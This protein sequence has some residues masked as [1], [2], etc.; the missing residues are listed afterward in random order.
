MAN[1]VL[2]AQKTAPQSNTYLTSCEWRVVDM[3]T[4]Y[5]EHCLAGKPFYSFPYFR[6]V[7]TL[8]AI[9]SESFKA[10]KQHSDTSDIIFSANMAMNVFVSVFTSVEFLSKGLLTL[11]AAGL[12]E[13]LGIEEN[14]TAFQRETGKV[15]K[16][17]VDLIRDD[18]FYTVPYL[19]QLKDLYQQFYQANDKSLIDAY[20]LFALSIE[21]FAKSLISLPFWG[22]YQLSELI[23]HDD[24]YWQRRLTIAYPE[25]T[26]DAEKIALKERLQNDVASHIK[27]N[28]NTCY[29]DQIEFEHEDGEYLQIKCGRYENL[30]TVI[31]I[32][33]TLKF[34]LCK[35]EGNDFVQLCLKQGGD[36]HQEDKKVKAL[37]EGGIRLNYSYQ[38]S[39]KGREQT[40]FSLDV[41]VRELQ[42]LNHKLDQ[43]DTPSSHFLHGF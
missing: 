26:T 4:E 13:L 31:S 42:A 34:S 21:H 36:N 40:F 20:T 30:V 14:K 3:S 37:C 17:Y 25:N 2:D 8:W 35:I 5:A 32:L 38:N 7:G 1:T 19:R 22:F 23:T 9:F 43:D 28:E 11:P 27:P 41:P 10:A 29:Q 16:E 12:S 39:I 33:S 18:A 24:S 6:Q 15:A